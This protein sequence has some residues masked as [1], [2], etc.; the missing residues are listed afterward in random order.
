MGSSDDNG[1][2]VKQKLKTE[3]GKIED[4]TNGVYIEY[5]GKNQIIT[6][7]NKQNN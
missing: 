7:K 2:T 4:R 1:E 5:K 6:T 3:L